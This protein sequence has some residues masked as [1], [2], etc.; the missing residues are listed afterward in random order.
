MDKIYYFSGTGNTLAAAKQVAAA[1]SNTEL[2]PIADLQRG[3]NVDFGDAEAVGI[4]TPV[5]CFGIPTVVNK[6]V[7]RIKECEEKKQPF[8][9]LICTSGGMIGSA[10]LVMTQL[11]GLRGYRLNAFYHVVMPSNYIPLSAPPAPRK[12]KKILDAAE[13][14]LALIIPKIAEHK[15]RRPVRVFPLNMI[16]ELVAKR[17]VSY[18]SDYDKYFWITEDCNSCGLCQDI[19]PASNIIIMNGMPTWRSQ[20]EQCMACLQWCP[21]KAIQ[22]K[23][24]TKKRHRYHHPDITAADLIRKRSEPHKTEGSNDVPD[25]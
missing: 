9:Y 25:A 20:C 5:Y 8:I 15:S 16:G 2:I 14:K 19:C 17:A 1:L 6:F 23:N 12:R 4:F 13:K 7:S 21:R 24:V 3:E 18:M 11:L 22:F 10:H